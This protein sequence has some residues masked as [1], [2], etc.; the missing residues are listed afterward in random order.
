[1]DYSAFSHGQ[2]QSKL[3]LCQELEKF[4]TTPV[5]VAI[6]GSWYNLLG[7]M[8]VTRNYNLYNYIHGIDFND[9]VKDIAD[10]I[11]N[12]WMINDDKKI[13]NINEDME[14][15]RYEDYDVVINT[16]VE[17]MASSKW[18]DKLPSNLECL[19]WDLRTKL[20]CIQSNNLTP[21]KIQKYENWNILN[22]NPDIESL[23]NK[24]PMEEILYE[25]TK[26][27]DYGELKYSRYM[28]IGRK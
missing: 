13:L 28:L 5:N 14:T 6:L 17:D 16:S 11:C 26:E 3:W 9:Q 2:I 12:A 8:M 4:I 18:F 19:N 23:K 21:D 25:G 10:K 15:Y 22:P 20:I 1:M 27:F 7:F 24:F